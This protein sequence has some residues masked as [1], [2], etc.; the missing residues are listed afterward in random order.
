MDQ[1]WQQK[2]PF[3]SIFTIGNHGKSLIDYIHI[4]HGIDRMIFH[5]QVRLPEK[6][7]TSTTADDNPNGPW[8]CYHNWMG[9]KN[10]SSCVRNM[11]MSI[12][13]DSTPISLEKD[14]YE[15]IYDI[16]QNIR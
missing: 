6:K 5:C 1:T 2:P 15:H 16:V 10:G 4:L 9:R 13:V 3:S 7:N 11:S 8:G 12:G 14:I